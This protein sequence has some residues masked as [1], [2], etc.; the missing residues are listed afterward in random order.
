MCH[1]VDYAATL[2]GVMR[3]RLSVPIWPARSDDVLLVPEPPR[4]E[5]CEMT[6][7]TRTLLSWNTRRV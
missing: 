2:W 4:I 6:V 1:G 3:T 7:V 5:W